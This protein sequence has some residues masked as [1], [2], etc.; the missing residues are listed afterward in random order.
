MR[1]DGVPPDNNEALRWFQ[2]AAAGG[3]VIAMYNAAF[4]DMALKNDA[5]AVKWLRMAAEK[6]LP[7]AQAGL[8]FCYYT[9]RGVVRDQV[10]GVKW[11]S[12]AADQG[13]AFGEYYLGAA[14]S[15]GHGGLPKNQQIGVTWYLRAA[16]QGN[17]L[18]RAALGK[19]YFL[20]LGV[21]IDQATAAKWT[22]LAAEDGD[23]ESMNNLAFILAGG[24]GV[25]K[26][27]PQA[28]LWY[29]RSAAFGLPNPMHSLAGI[30]YLAG[31]MVEADY[32]ARLAL[33]FYAPTAPKL[34]DIRALLAQ[35]EAATSEV[36]KAA[37]QRRVD[38]FSP[39]PFVPPLEP[40]APARIVPSAPS[41]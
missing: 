8:G 26:D 6:G 24:F 9:G 10:E 15:F 7:A 23:A 12:R 41:P 33:R 37:V 39:R 13:N 40:H 17:P 4:A 25:A 21:A 14:Y 2:R 5:D 34:A 3:N 31:N 29:E 36:D 38:A 35:I 11:L 30:H 19:A 1:G 18:A 32:W 20:G 16:E 22:R 28:I 27:V